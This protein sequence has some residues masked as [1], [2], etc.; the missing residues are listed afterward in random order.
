MDDTLEF[1]SLPVG[2][3]QIRAADA[4]PTQ[5]VGYAAV[6]DQLSEDLGFFREKSPTS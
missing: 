5:I 6:F 4:A 1:R 3:I 2:Q